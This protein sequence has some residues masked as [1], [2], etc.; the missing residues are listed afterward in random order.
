MIEKQSVSVTYTALG[1]S[2]GAGVGA[3]EGGGYVARLFVRI[4]K[5]RP[6]SRLTNLC[7]SGATT[8]NVLHEQLTPAISSRPTLITLGIGIN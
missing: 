3:R 2:T 1:D 5:E 8:E 7:V 6:D 4:K